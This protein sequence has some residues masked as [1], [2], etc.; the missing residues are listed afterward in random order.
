MDS[1]L[2]DEDDK[3]YHTDN[4]LFEIDKYTENTSHI[5]TSQ[6]CVLTPHI[7]VPNHMAWCKGLSSPSL[8]I[9]YCL[10]S[11]GLGWQYGGYNEFSGLALVKS[12]NY[13]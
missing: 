4:T 12:C 1:A 2:S 5:E 13:T 8:S 11:G 10:W 9:E 7:Q 6:L 3:S